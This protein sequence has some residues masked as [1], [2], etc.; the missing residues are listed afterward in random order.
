MT[1][2]VNPMGLDEL[3]RLLD[4]IVKTMQRMRDAMNSADNDTQR[5]LVAT[6]YTKALVAKL[7]VKADI[8]RMTP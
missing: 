1:T 4:K 3:H 7:Q 6:L 5:G 2:P 8:E